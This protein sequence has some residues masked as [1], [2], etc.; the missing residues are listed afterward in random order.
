M[1][2]AADDDRIDGYVSMASGAFAAEGET[3]E[4]PAKPS[5]FLGGTVDAVVPAEDVT[6]PE[7][8]RAHV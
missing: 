7:I 6:R 5:F 2:A 4:M 3:V 8:G 1:L